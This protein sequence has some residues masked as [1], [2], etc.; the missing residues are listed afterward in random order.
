M[1]R[2][3]RGP[4]LGALPPDPRSLALGRPTPQRRRTRPR[5]RR[6]GPL[7]YR[8]PPGA[9]VA[10]LRSPI[11]PT[12]TGSLPERGPGVQPQSTPGGGPSRVRGDILTTADIP[13]LVKQRTFLSWS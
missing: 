13:T 8:R 1:P 12:A 11:L 9:R 2:S 5:L 7:A 10:L 3:R 6:P 4:A